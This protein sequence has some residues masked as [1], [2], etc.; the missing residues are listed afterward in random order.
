ML[1]KQWSK[2]QGDLF[3]IRIL[4]EWGLRSIT[5]TF[6]I[7]ILNG[8]LYVHLCIM[9]LVQL[10]LYVELFIVLAMVIESWT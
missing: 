6:F 3:F 7:F 10:A 4:E 2:Q 1:I 9:L 8:T 5:G